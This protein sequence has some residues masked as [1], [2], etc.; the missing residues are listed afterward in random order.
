M[1]SGVVFK[2]TD[3]ALVVVLDTAP[4]EALDRPL[5]LEVLANEV[6]CYPHLCSE[7]GIALR[8]RVCKAP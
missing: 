5:Q 8:Q 4:K 3:E 1:L 2:I 6:L 7:P